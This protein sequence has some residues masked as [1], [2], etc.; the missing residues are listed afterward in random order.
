MTVTAGSRDTGAVSVSAGSS[1]TFTTSN[2]NAAQTVTV[3]GV[4]DDDDADESTTVDLDASGG[5]Y[6]A[7]TGEVTVNVDDDD[8]AGLVLDPTTVPVVEGDT[9]TFTVK[10]ATQPTGDVTVAAASRDAGAVS[11]TAGSSLTF[12]TSN[13]N[14]AQ[15]VTV[16]GV[17]DGDAVDESTTVDLDASG[18]GYGPVAGEVTV[19]VTDDDDPAVTVS[20]GSASYSVAEGSTTV[21]EVV[22]SADPER[23]VTVPITAAPI[24]G[25]SAADYSGVPASVVFNSGDTEKTFM[26]AATDDNVDDDGERVRLTFGALP[27][28]VSSAAPSQAVVSITDDDDA[29]GLVLDPTTVPVVEGDTATF[30]VKLAT[31]PTGM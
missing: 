18:G 27:A 20:F 6:S 8:T 14:A 25:A 23:T 26:F 12:T 21:V 29:A 9:A 1:L 7:V 13:W 30:T 5:G 10:L 15:T 31:E 4:D 19:N 24:N 22:L 2:W 16:A 11:V 3:A 17:Q 28:R